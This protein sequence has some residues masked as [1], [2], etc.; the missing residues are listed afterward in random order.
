MRKS[1]CVPKNYNALMIRHV[2]YIHK[3]DIWHLFSLYFIFNVV[4]ISLV[5]SPIKCHNY[6]ME[7]YWDNLDV[8]HIM[9]SNR[10]TYVT[11]RMRVCCIFLMKNY[12]LSLPL[13]QI[14]LF[15]L[16]IIERSV[17]WKKN[18]EKFLMRIIWTPY[19]FPICDIYRACMWHMSHD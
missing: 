15:P 9:P 10:Y 12:L 19:F 16:A 5:L 11:Y 4:D 2:C 6:V 14:C 1:W 13:C 17:Y 8:R 18:H 3:C 7:G